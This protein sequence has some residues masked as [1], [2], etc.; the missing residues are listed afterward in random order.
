MNK[1][2]LLTSNLLFTCLK[3]NKKHN[4]T[5]AK[6]CSCGNDHFI[7]SERR[8]NGPAFNTYNENTNSYRDK[9]DEESGYKLTTPGN[10]GDIGQSGLGSVKDRIPGFNRSYF[11]EE[12][13]GNN[14]PSDSPLFDDQN[15]LN[16]NQSSDKWFDS[17]TIDDSGQDNQTP[18]HPLNPSKKRRR[19]SKAPLMHT[20]DNTGSLF[21]RIRQFQ[22]REMISL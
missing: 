17:G 3:C 1:F 12:N 9:S 19:D 7:V 22:R 4:Y 21:D 5:T 8:F 18:Q 10:M 15:L 13:P 11:D 14:V 20:F 6:K 2:N 16:S